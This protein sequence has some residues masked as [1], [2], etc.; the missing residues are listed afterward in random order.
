MFGAMLLSSIV[1]SLLLSVAA[2]GPSID[3]QIAFLVNSSSP[4]INYPTDFTQNIVPKP[5]HSHNDYWRQVPLLTAL[6]LGVASVEAD[7]W[8]FNGTLFVGHELAALTPNRTFSSLYVEPLM[9]IL[10]MQNPKDDFTVNQTGINGVFDMAGSIPLQLLV[11]I[12][13]DGVETLPFVQAQLEPLRARGYLTTF[14]NGTLRE[15]AITVVGTGNTPLDPVKALEPRDFFFDAPLNQL[16]DPSLNTTWGPGLSPLASVDWNIAVGWS[17]I[18]NI[19][20]TQL[21]NLTQ[22]VNDAHS[23]GIRARYWDLPGWP[24][25]ARTAIW[26]TLILSGVDWLNADD[27]EAAANF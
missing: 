14:T 23:L 10:A 4:Q 15:S 24:I 1:L 22:F 25:S 12:K 9:Q 8:L 18:G 7:V 13:T 16:T 11:D 6:S 3:R 2:Q 26:E 21:G 5:I 19:S 27:L 17:G 20:A